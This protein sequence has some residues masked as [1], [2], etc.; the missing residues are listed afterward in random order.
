MT[1]DTVTKA[2]PIKANAWWRFSGLVIR[3]LMMVIAV[4]I[5]GLVIFGSLTL[6]TNLA[7][8]VRTLSL[9]IS[10][11]ALVVILWGNRAVEYKLVWVMLV[12]LFPFVGGI[13]YL[14]YGD[15]RPGKRIRLAKANIKHRAIEALKDVDCKVE[16]EEVDE[17]YDYRVAQQVNYLTRSGEFVAFEN[18]DV[19]YYA[20]GEDA[21]VEMLAAMENAERYICAEYFIIS[22]GHMFNAMFDVMVRKAA[23]GVDVKFMYDDMGSMFKLPNRVLGRAKE[24]GIR[25]VPVNRFDPRTLKFNNRDHRKLLIIDGEVGFTGGI[26]IGDEYINIVDHFGL[27]KD[28]MLKLEG[29]AVFGMLGLFYSIWDLI[30]KDNTDL[31]SLR[32]EL[33]ERTT[34]GWVIPFD[35]SPF[36]DVSVGWAAHRN[37]M[38]RAKH[39]ID[40]FTPYLI[41]SQYMVEE[42]AGLALSG[43]SVRI[44]TPGVPDKWLV[45][46]AT[47]ANY[48]ALLEAG[49]EIY[50]FSPGFMHAKQM[51]VDDDF[52][53]LGTINMDFRSFYLHQENAIWM[54]GVPAISDLKKDMEQTRA[55]SH[56]VTLEEVNA[57]PGWL[58]VIQR[59]MKIMTPAI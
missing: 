8:G 33:A 6:A 14:I 46:Q 49:V 38:S 26:N 24:A 11:I 17:H 53:I 1:V 35:D 27:W 39:S 43:I 45:W 59:V 23:A 54:Y 9:I 36:D 28:T 20:W 41:P 56:R 34:P 4:A 16:V 2:P 12:L 7:T 18:T 52:A 30:T 22:E 13:F 25:M 19:T 51:V 55:V 37:M 31:N 47:K 10:L 21:F 58:K 48:Q 29:A 57:T 44:Y 5:Q 40:L 15:Q 50:E 42:I 32:P 3:V